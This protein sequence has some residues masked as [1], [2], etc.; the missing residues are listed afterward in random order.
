M[1]HDRLMQ[2]IGYRREELRQGKVSPDRYL[3]PGARAFLE[4]FRNRGLKLYCA[5]GT[6]EVYTLEEARLLEIDHY[7]DG[8]I[9]GARND[10]KS[11]SKE[12]L[13]RQMVSSVRD[14]WRRRNS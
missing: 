14:E 13:I 12:T 9:Y 6:D 8:R 2:K 11:F 1:Y 4:S 3:L 10:Y 7:F 5:S